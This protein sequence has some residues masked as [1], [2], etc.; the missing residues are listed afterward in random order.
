MSGTSPARTLLLTLLLFVVL[1]RF[2]E[3]S[4]GRGF[5]NNERQ[6]RRTFPT[7][8]LMPRTSLPPSIPPTMGGLE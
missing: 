7:N 3:Q 8:V 2:V 5:E 4:V 6:V 1:C